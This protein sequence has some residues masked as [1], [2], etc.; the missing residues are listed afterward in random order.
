MAIWE[1]SQR[2]S[3]SSSIQPFR[4]GRRSD[5]DTGQL[6]KEKKSRSVLKPAYRLWV[7]YMLIMAY[8][9]IPASQSKVKFQVI[10]IFWM[11][12]L[13]WSE[14]QDIIIGFLYFSPFQWHIGEI[15]D[16]QTV[17]HGLYYLSLAT[18][19]RV[20]LWVVSGEI[21]ILCSL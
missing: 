12:K 8:G 11:Y 7:R 6:Q 21:T 15:K 5:L 4:K 20:E 19:N 3:A 1:T 2:K 13:D 18:F 10:S 9:S 16:Y 14:N 17:F